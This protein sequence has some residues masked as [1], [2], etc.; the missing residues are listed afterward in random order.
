MPKETIKV[1]IQPVPKVSSINGSKIA[2]VPA[3][4]NLMQLFSAITE[5][6]RVGYTS[7]KYVD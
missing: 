5:T 2:T 7:T 3:T 4:I 1:N 6:L